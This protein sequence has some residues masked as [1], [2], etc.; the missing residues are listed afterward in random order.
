M[1]MAGGKK[2]AIVETRGSAGWASVPHWDLVFPS[3]YMGQKSGYE[4]CDSDCRMLL[5]WFS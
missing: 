2:F 5:L 1:K 4:V 3:R